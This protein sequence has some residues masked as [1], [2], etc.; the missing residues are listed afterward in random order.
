[1]IVTQRK[2]FKSKSIFKIQKWIIKR[3]TNYAKIKFKEV[4]V[5]I[6]MGITMWESRSNS[7]LEVACVSTKAAVTKNFWSLGKAF[8][9]TNL[10]I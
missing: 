1:M 4:F 2:K 10:R 3:S 5:F 7:L 9:S 6:G 8:N